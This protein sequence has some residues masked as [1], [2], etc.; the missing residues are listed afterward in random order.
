MSVSP[1]TAFPGPYASHLAKCSVSN[2]S[3]LWWHGGHFYS[4]TDPT[5]TFTPHIRKPQL[6]TASDPTN[7]SSVPS[8]V[9]TIAAAPSRRNPRRRP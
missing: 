1:I 2:L 7:L 9:R 3:L 8:R 4:P 6:N 5:A